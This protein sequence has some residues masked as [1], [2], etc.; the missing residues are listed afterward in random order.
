MVSRRDVKMPAR[1]SFF[2]REEKPTGAGP[3][4]RLCG[5]EKRACVCNTREIN[6]AV[7]ARRLICIYYEIK[8]FR[9]FNSARRAEF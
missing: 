2:L 7:V 1:P 3:A 6:Y 8:K 5:G 4:G 9:D